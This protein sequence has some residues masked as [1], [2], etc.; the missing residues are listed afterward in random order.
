MIIISTILLV[1]GF[2]QYNKYN[3]EQSSYGLV[4]A[5]VNE[6]KFEGDRTIVGFEYF[7]N[8]RYYFSSVTTDEE[9][10]VGEKRKIYFL[11]NNPEVCKIH[12]LSIFKTLMYFSSGILLLAGSILLNIKG[13]M[14][15]IRIKRLKK[16]G[17]LVK[18]NIQ[19]VLVIN[20]NT[21]KN[22]YKI[23]ASYD[24][25]KDNKTYIFISE[26]EKTDLKDLVSRMSVKIIDVYINQNNTEDYYVD[27]ESIKI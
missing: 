10:E 3:E 26:E 6:V 19:E 16:K 13:L 2:V 7:L 14:R 18:A 12:L 17:L 8:E 20:K 23:R 1:L 4:N 21:G 24:N 9:F 5:T 15:K 27:I 11:K 22:P 25:P